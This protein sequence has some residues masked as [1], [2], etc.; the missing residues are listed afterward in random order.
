MLLALA[1]LAAKP[2]PAN[3]SDDR[4][5]IN[6]LM[7][8]YAQALDGFNPDAYAALYTTDGQFRAGV[9]ATKGQQALK[10]MI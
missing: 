1:V 2:A 5:E 10:A 7:W 8:R 3:R 9:N 4:E 6:T